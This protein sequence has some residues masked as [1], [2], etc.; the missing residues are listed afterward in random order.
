MNIKG[1]DLGDYQIKNEHYADDLWLAL[2][3]TTEN[4]N[5]L[6]NELNAFNKF[7]GLTINYN[8]SVAMLLG[9]MRD[10]D[11]KFY[12]MRKLFWS[13]GLKLLGVYIHLD[14]R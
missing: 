7:S 13:D 8:K 11:A 6:L 12:T 2:D 4:I 10:T 5:N 9:P 14:W 3:P 1:I